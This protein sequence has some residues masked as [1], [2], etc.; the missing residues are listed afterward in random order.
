MFAAIALLLVGVHSV[1]DQTDPRLITLFGQLQDSTNPAV[2]RRAESEIWA[3]WHET[4]DDKSLDI[5]RRAR[6]ALDSGDFPSAIQLMDQLVAYA[7][8]YAE[9]WNQR[10]IV[11]YLAEDYAGS[12]RD[13][14]QALAL[15]PRHFGALSGRGQNY[16]RLDEPELALQAFE[17]ALALN[18][19][20]A[21]VRAQMGMIRALLGSRQKPI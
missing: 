7:P 18:P 13:I 9:A 3:I 1:A 19:W 20:M 14:E 11:S 6:M 8:G 16:L 12:L 2:A 4:P 10:A 5:M 21:N 15:E 17:S